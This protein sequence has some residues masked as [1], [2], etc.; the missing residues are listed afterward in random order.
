[1]AQ[2]TQLGL[3]DPGGPIVGRE[4]ELAKV[5]AF[6]GSGEGPRAFVLAGD[7]GIGKTTLWE[8][9]VAAA[10][11]RGL[12]VL[13]A[14]G[15]GA[16]TRLSFAALIDLL[17][18]IGSEELGDLPPPQLHALEVALLRADAT[19][20]VPPEAHAISIGFLNALRALAAG[21]PLLVAIDD[22]QWLDAASGDV[23]AFAARRLEAEPV[24]FLL[25]R[26]PGP[27]SDM[28]RALERTVP[29]RLEMLSLSFGATRRLLSDHLGLSLPRHVLRRVFDSTLGNPLFALEMGRS[30]VIHGLPAAGE[31]VPVPDAVDDLLGSR[32]AELPRP[33]RRLL[34]ALALQADLRVQQL[35][36][37]SGSDA[38]ED[39]VDAGV[40]LL[41]ADRV[42]PSHPLLAAAAR[43]RARGA[44]R[45]EL[46]LQ[47]A[48]VVAD[49]ELRA[50]HLALATKLPDEDL[51]S[52]AAAAAAAA[53]AHGAAR[54]AVV[55]AE[56]ALRLTP[57][58]STHRSGRLLDLAG[59][60]E[61]AGERRRVTDLLTPELDS[62][63]TH[64]RVR[65][66]LR[67]SEGGAIA[68]V[69]DSDAYLDLAWPHTQDAPALRAHV[70]AKKACQI[71]ASVCGIRDA[72]AWAL[73]ALG[74]AEDDPVL[75]RL[76][77]HGLG[78][79]RA[80]RGL[81][82]DDVCD[83]FRAA[84]D[85]AFHITDSPDPVAGLRL[86]WRGHVDEARMI[87]TQFMTLADARG[88]EV[89][90]ALQR[91]QVCDLEL[92]VGEWEAAER[93][94]DEWESADRQL[95]IA[96][97][98]Q[99]SRGLLAAG[100]GFADEAE[101]W[102]ARSLAGAEPGGYNW[103]LLE[104]RRVRGI[105]AL[106]ARE[107]ARAVESLGAAWAHLERE[108]VDEPGAFPVAA[109]LVEALVELERLD[110]ARQVVRRLRSLAEEQ[111]HPWGLVTARRCDALLRLVSTGYDDE[112]ATALAAASEDYGA[113]GLRFDS[114]R[115]LLTLGRA[116]RRHRKWG[117][118]RTSL[119]GAASAFDDLGSPGWADEARSELSR[120]GGRRPGATD[121][122]TPT[123]RRV[124]ELAADGLANKEIASALF[125]SVRTVEEHL[126][127]AYAKL[128]IR[129]RTQLARRLSELP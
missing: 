17:D 12:R 85:A 111:R 53:S 22:V 50:L 43:K 51:A 114:A 58:D 57:P 105:A 79:A 63:S 78:W 46:H 61:V 89:S 77:L 100:R 68:S 103:Q 34:L 128:G 60:L 8:A 14:R 107:P 21:R 104:A 99:R 4:T 73:E 64:D 106:L 11:E 93:L 18:G 98:Y 75:Q 121:E 26:R 45:R 5:H 38:I 2:A 115:S 54:D 84:S 81:P 97:T 95:L 126:K 52:T 118:A 67:L 119:E 87:L 9:G 27:V 33:V 62:L 117:A 28:E 112:A 23:L 69:A 40:V 36:A 19:S 113:L 59:Y 35:T 41:E 71:A 123:E 7:P 108:G 83:R 16:E 116:Q 125:V 70:L 44:E 80:L 96:A 72:E 102:A 65:A 90:Y 56:H 66:W 30:L 94:L 92:R 122:L 124:A 129:S 127:K 76:A 88:E 74:D 91:M 24:A 20:G 110:E 47:L 3:S 39:A 13:S 10:R 82:I 15:S 101:R 55:L 120:V 37:I 32:V 109:D 6:L 48:T 29:D 1:M 49:G 42:R 86:L 31:D 25:A